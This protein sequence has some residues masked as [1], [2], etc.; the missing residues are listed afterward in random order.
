MT[1]RTLI[2]AINQIGKVMNIE[3]IAKHVENVFTLNQ[4]VEIGINFAQGIYL[5]EP[6]KF[7]GQVESIQR[8][9][10]QQTRLH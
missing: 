8:L 2:V 1:D 3:T 10:K 4:L 9:K 7:S 5:H 6:R